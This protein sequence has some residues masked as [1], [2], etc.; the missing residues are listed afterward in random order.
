M[1]INVDAS[2]RA[3]LMLSLCCSAYDDFVTSFKNSQLER[4]THAKQNVTLSSFFLSNGKISQLWIKNT[5]LV[6][7]LYI[8]IKYRAVI[9]PLSPSIIMNVIPTT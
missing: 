8:C 6:N 7:E 3:L 2:N 4:F 5:I 1:L 9:V